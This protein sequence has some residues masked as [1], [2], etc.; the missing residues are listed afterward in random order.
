MATILVHLRKGSIFLAALF[1]LALSGCTVSSRNP[2]AGLADSEEVPQY[3]L[4]SWSFVELATL[5]AAGKPGG[6]D[7]QAAADGSLRILLTENAGTLA[8]SASLATVGG[9][10]ILSIAPQPSEERW[11][12]AS[13]VFDEPTQQLTV[14]LLHQAV[15]LEDIQLGRVQG[16]IYQFDQ[17]DMAN[18]TASPEQLR[19]YIA[20]HGEA[21]FSDRMMIVEKQPTP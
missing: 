21:A 18:L 11:M 3:L 17:A 6:I 2:L 1:V 9:L 10:Q 15:V 5:D 16:E 14:N 7:L 4:G 19:T 8:L 20:A 12:L 13:L